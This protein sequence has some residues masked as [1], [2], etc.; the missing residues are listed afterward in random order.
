MCDIIELNNIYDMIYIKERIQCDFYVYRYESDLFYMW[1]GLLCL[2]VWI[3]RWVKYKNVP[4]TWWLSQ[5][6]YQYQHSKILELLLQAPY[7]WYTFIYIYI[8]I[9]LCLCLCMFRN[10]LY[11]I[12]TVQHLMKY[13]TKHGSRSHKR[14]EEKRRMTYQT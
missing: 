3:G 7:L 12:V 14:R 1:T 4:A 2:N 5:P 10:I 6:G 13:I 9:C 11:E 8:Y